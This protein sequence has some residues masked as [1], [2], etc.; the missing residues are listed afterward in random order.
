[1][2]CSIKS[3]LHDNFCAIEDNVKRH[4]KDLVVPESQ[5]V[6]LSNSCTQ[7]DSGLE[8]VERS[9]KEKPVPSSDGWV[10]FR[11]GK[12]MWKESWVKL[13]GEELNKIGSFRYS[14]KSDELRVN[15]DK[16]NKNSQ[17]KSTRRRKSKNLEGATVKNPVDL[18]ELEAILKKFGLTTTG[19]FK[20][21]GS[22][23]NPIRKQANN[24]R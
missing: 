10:T 4:L 7:T 20:R 17:K 2:S 5:T 13:S 16:N 8:G 18:D 22:G 15:K 21:N 14:D 6:I 1:M 12:R 3:T 24:N 23:R 11:S 9:E 19:N